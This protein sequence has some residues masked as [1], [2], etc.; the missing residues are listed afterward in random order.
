M[1]KI[2]TVGYQGKLRA[3]LLRN[4]HM[5]KSLKSRPATLDST[6]GLAVVPFV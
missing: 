3:D 4:M 2:K 1:P 5:S 6:G